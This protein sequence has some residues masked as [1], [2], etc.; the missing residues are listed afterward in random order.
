M[1]CELCGRIQQGEWT[2]GDFFIFHQPQM[3]SICEACRQQFTRITGP[4]C[5]ECGCQSQISPCAECEIWLTAGYSAIH[6]QALFAYDE[7]MQQYFKQYKFQGG[8]HLR[9]VFQ[10]MLAQRL[11]KVA[12]TM[13]VPIPITAE[14]QNQ[15]GFNQVSSWLEKCEI[16]EILTCISTSKAVQSMKTRRERLQTT[17]PF[18]L[19]TE[20][21]DL[22]GQRICIVDDVYTT[23][24]TLR[25]ASSCLYESGATQI[26]TVTLA[27]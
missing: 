18:C 7:Q 25:H 17:Q 13:I 9:D 11:V 16:N 27:R 19:V 21:L 6:N 1:T 8:Y 22:T 14:T 12:P 4:V 5:A 20:N 23:G 2:L 3:L 26:C 15:R 10:Q 24:R